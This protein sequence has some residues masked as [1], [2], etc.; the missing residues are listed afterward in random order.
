MLDMVETKVMI[1]D[2][3]MSPSNIMVQ[4]LDADPPGEQP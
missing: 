2:K 4:L 1:A 3:S